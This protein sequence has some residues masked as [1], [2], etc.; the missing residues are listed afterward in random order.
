MSTFFL[1]DSKGLKSLFANRTILV[2]GH[3]LLS[4][5][6]KMYYTELCVQ[7]SQPTVHFNSIQFYLYMNK[8]Q[9]SPQSVVYGKNPTIFF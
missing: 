7:W 5:F 1:T 9:K 6:L 8:S 3:V 2:V 4:N